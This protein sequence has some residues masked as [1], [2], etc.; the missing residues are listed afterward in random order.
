ML[1]NL[2]QLHG[3]GQVFTRAL[4]LGFVV[5]VAKESDIPSET[6]AVGGQFFNVDILTG[7]LRQ[8]GLKASIVGL[9][10]DVISDTTTEATLSDV[11]ALVNFNVICIQW[12]Q[13]GPKHYTCLT[14]VHGNFFY[15]DSLRAAPIFVPKKSV[16]GFIKTLRANGWYLGIVEKVSETNL[17]G[18]L[19]N[20]ELFVSQAILSE[21][22][23][24]DCERYADL[25]LP[26]L[27]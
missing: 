24:R 16:C 3:R 14:Q 19:A 6:L 10:K 25:D 21:E 2:F 1:N 8:L 4:M 9:Y 18:S 13:R 12:S 20:L 7:I 22:S 5:G 17:A 15:C 26:S 23:K 11:S 27:T